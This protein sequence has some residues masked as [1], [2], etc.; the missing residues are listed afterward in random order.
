MAPECRQTRD[1]LSALV[2]GELDDDRRKIVSA[3][4]LSCPECSR[5]VGGLLAAK[6]MTERATQDAGVPA[7]F[8][9]HVR[10]R[11]DEVDSVRSRVMRSAPARRLVG[12]AAVGAIAVSLAIIFSTIFY[13]KTDRAAVL[14]RIHRQVAGNTIVAIAPDALS[15]V[16][17]N[18]AVDPWV[19][20][21]RGLVRVDE[22]FIDYTLYR[23]GMCPVSVFK[24]PAG[25]SPYRT[26]RLVSERVGGFDVRQ[27]EGQSM[28]LLRRAGS[29]TVLVAAVPPE[30][31]AAIAR[32]WNAHAGRSPGW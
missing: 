27:V 7:G 12:I 31:L 8:Y 18:P 28:T 29:T 16:S 21:R 3:H 11:L 30:E 17:C 9:A 4:V 15:T 13:I 14:A 2:D 26:G 20:L 5:V 19:E 22:G 6:R 10:S 25:W 23:V 24:G 32:A 1:L